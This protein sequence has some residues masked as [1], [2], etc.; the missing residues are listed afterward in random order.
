[1]K[2]LILTEALKLNGKSCCKMSCQ[3][4][5]QCVIKIK[6]QVLYVPVL[7]YKINKGEKVKE[8]FKKVEQFYRE[9]YPE[10]CDI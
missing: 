10:W 9:Y 1:M 2:A 3:T 5:K 8:E 6:K 4:G 7:L